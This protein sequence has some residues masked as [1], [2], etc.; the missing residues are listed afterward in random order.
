MNKINKMADKI[1][2]ID[3]DE[4]LYSEYNRC[5]IINEGHTCYMNSIIQTIYNIPIL[6]KNVMEVNIEENKNK[7]S[8]IL[9]EMQNIFAKL[10]LCKFNISLKRLFPKLKFQGHWNSNQ[11]AHEYY[12]TIMDMISEFSNNIYK[13]T[14]GILLNIIEVKQKKYYSMK[15]E[16]FMFVELE[17]IKA[18]NLEDCLKQYFSEE[19]L[20]GDNKIEIMEKGKKCYYEGTKIIKLKK[21][22]DIFHICLKRFKF[23]A[24]TR[25]FYKLNKKISF[26][27]KID[28]TQYSY[29]K[30]L[31]QKFILYSILIHSGEMNS[32]HYFIIIRDFAKN[33]FIKLNDTEVTHVSPQSV[34]NDYCGG[35]Y[36]NQNFDIKLKLEK[37]TNIY[38]LIYV[39]ESKLKILFDYKSITK[40]IYLKYKKNG[41][42]NSNN[43]PNK[44]KNDKIQNKV[45]KNEK[46]KEEEIKIKNDKNQNKVVKIA[47]L[48]EEKTEIKNDKTKNEVTKIAPLKEEETKLKIDKTKNEVT[49]IA[50]Q[51]E[52][53]SKIKND[54]VVDIIK[55]EDISKEAKQ[56]KI[57]AV[58]TQRA[59]PYINNNNKLIESEKIFNIE[60]YKSY[61]KGT[62]NEDFDSKTNDN[63]MVIINDEAINYDK[64]INIRINH[65]IQNSEQNK[66]KIES[67]KE[68]ENDK[69]NSID[70]INWN[71]KTYTKYLFYINYKLK[72]Q[73]YLNYEYNKPIFLKEVPFIIYNQL[74]DFGK[75][76]NIN[77]LNKVF[78]YKEY[79]IFLL[80]NFG[81]II[82]I[83]QN[84]DQDIYNFIKPQLDF[85]KELIVN[86]VGI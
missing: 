18:H 80:N 38:F 1:V 68:E 25:S 23:N 74:K 45:T 37:E 70:L 24:K 40:N 51:K 9:K 82:Y 22:P 41:K 13:L 67:E 56:N 69:I 60:K 34:Y 35:Y 71:K 14:H 46:P 3:F 55:K 79:L 72:Y 19:I 83:L 44:I 15:E 86:N 63:K 61:K 78:Y 32:G 33:N 6:V 27:E 66:R 57:K 47:P 48:K 43:N 58:Y 4:Y 52:K 2:K 26:P 5:G 30:N 21:I 7:N 75:K 12:T 54:I 59:M 64:L 36:F 42:K 73:D 81:I 29:N 17:I 84:L 11:D 16:E 39:N 28:F 20:K 50:Q 65:N 77:F 31:K 85:S 10:N 62:S 53:E 49:K 76:I 8:E